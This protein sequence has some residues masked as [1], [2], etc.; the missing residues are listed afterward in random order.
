V[1]TLLEYGLKSIFALRATSI[2]QAPGK[3]RIH[4]VYEHGEIYWTFASCTEIAVT[5]FGQS[6]VAYLEI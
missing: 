2:M 4:S 6:A 5:F 3:V 1:Q